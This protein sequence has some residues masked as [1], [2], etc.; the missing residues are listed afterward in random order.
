[1]IKAATEMRNKALNVV[2]FKDGLGIKGTKLGRTGS[3]LGRKKT[4]VWSLNL[5]GQI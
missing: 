5:S 2:I 4:C 3:D 1:M